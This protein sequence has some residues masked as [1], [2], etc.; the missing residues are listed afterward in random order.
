MLQMPPVLKTREPCDEILSEDPAL[1]GLETSSIIFTDIT[2]GKKDSE[3]LIVVREPDGTLRK[4]NWQLR[5]RMNQVYFPL[6][7]RELSM[8][9]LFRPDYLKNL[10]DAKEYEFIL[11]RACLQFEPN[12]PEYQKVTSLTYTHVS[13]NDSFDLLRSTR[14]FGPLT[15]F[16]TWF[17]MVDNLLLDLIQ[18]ERINE[19]RT[20]V[21][22]YGRVHGVHFDLKAENLVEL[23]IREHAAK[24]AP[25]EL[26]MQAFKDL[27]RQRRE[28]QSGIDKAHGRL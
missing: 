8:P 7:G 25:L 2:F 23:F 24:K 13:D 11:D 4:A 1:Q 28:L 17:K 5:D 20:L 19:A 26:A 27:D 12:D 21:E 18:T 9:R 22:L 10:L 16:L 6:K 14:H 3:R 15:F